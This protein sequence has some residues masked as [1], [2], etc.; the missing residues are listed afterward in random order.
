MENQS[1]VLNLLK[2]L[3]TKIQHNNYTTPPKYSEVSFTLY[4]NISQKNKDLLRS[5]SKLT[6]FSLISPLEILYKQ[7]YEKHNS[8]SNQPDKCSICLCEFYDDIID[9]NNNQ[10]ILKD[11][12]S[13][14]IHEI[15]TI[16]LF[17][18]HDHFFH[19]ECLLNYIKN[20][21]GF[22]CANCQNIYG[23]IIGNMPPGKMWVEVKDKLHCA[24][25]PYDGTI[26]IHYEFKNGHGYSGTR[27]TNFL[28]NTERG[29]EILGMLKIAFDRKLT[30]TVG[31]SVTTGKTNTVVWNGIHHKSSIDGGPTRYGY[32]D[33]GYFDRVEGELAEKGVV[34][35]EGL[36]EIALGLM[37]GGGY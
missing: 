23:I 11:F 28:P 5:L 30:F 27:R 36:E 34:K 32:P 29:R 19:I 9:Y 2:D 21:P 12:N 31:T 37:Y 1:N 4:N 33:E 22:K 25:Y 3:Y 7:Q 13:Y 24:G 10:L 14:I 8:I 26:I 16:K 17:K 20:Q 18:C 6:K 35:T 15:D